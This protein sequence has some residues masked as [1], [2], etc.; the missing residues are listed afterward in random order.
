ME[1]HSNL[2]LVTWDFT[3]K[4]V[5]ALEHAIN[6]AK[7]INH[8]IALINIVKKE[9]EVAETEK[10]IADAIRGKF[11]N[12]S[13]KAKIIVKAGTIFTTIAELAEEIKAQMVVMG[14]HGI[15]GMQKLLGSWALKVIAGSKS[16]FIVVQDSPK[17]ETLRKV[18]LPVTFKKENKEC[19]NWANY[20]AKKYGTKFYIFKAKNTDQSFIKG[21]DSNIYFINKFFN[22]KN[23]RY[24]IQTASVAGDFAKETVAY[25]KDIEADAILVMTTRDIKFTDYVLGAQEQYIIANT[26]KIPVVCINPRP[27]KLGGSFSASGG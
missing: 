27:I 13:I 1:E 6:L 21:V 14:T 16:P 10:K 8:D 17:G 3:D 7:V 19:V 12:I 23:I 22:S 2:V 26:E 9:S 4:S 18:V 15:R 25:A 20:F 5:F 24:D 11:E